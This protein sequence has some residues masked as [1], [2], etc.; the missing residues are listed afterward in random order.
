MDASICLLP[1]AAANDGNAMSRIASIIPRIKAGDKRGV[2][3]TGPAMLMEPCIMATSAA[4]LKAG[5]AAML[6]MQRTPVK[7]SAPIP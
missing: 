3:G 7:V 4:Q 6:A 5:L 2:A 1:C